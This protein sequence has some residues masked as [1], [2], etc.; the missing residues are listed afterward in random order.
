M[1]TFLNNVHLRKNGGFSAAE[2]AAFLDE[3]LRT[4]GNVPA[5]ADDADLAVAVY[6]SEGSGWISIYSDLYDFDTTQD[7]LQPL[8]ERFRTD[9]LAIGCF[10]SDFLC[11]NLINAQDGTD[12]FARVGSAAELGIR[13]RANLAA[14]KGK[15]T[16]WEAFRA[17]LREKRVFAD[18]ALIPLEKLLGLP[19]NQSNQI[20]EDFDGVAEGATYLYYSVPKSAQSTEPPTLRWKSSSG[21]G[22]ASHRE[23]ETEESMRMPYYVGFLNHGG[24]SRGLRIE[25][26]WP[27]VE[28]DDISFEAK[29]VRRDKKNHFEHIPIALK[30]ERT[31]TGDWVFSW[32]D[33]RFRIPACV[34]ENLPWRKK[35]DREFQNEISV[36]YGLKGNLRK[37]LDLR[38]RF[39]PLAAPE[40][41][42]DWSTWGSF[43]SKRAYAEYY[44]STAGLSPYNKPI[45]D[46]DYDLD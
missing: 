42:G 12:A 32:E 33:R 11:L 22:P 21:L 20:I 23:N 46:E 28:G 41:A 8:S 2:V 27:Y 30:K 16:D 10:D 34:D 40:G 36:Y 7:D 29:I 18:E 38:I 45:T 19:Y 39:I 9:A 5:S 6:A 43:G 17:A 37:L 15:V 44:N 24:A 1:G 4:A 31:K 3:R 13:R 26:I 35:M 14:W 25:F